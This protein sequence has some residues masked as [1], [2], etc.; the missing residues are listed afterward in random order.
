MEALRTGLRTYPGLA[1]RLVLCGEKAEVKAYNDSKATNV[2][3]T[4]TA[5][6]AL[7][8]PLVLLLGGQDKGTPYEPLRDFLTGKLRRLIFLGEAIPRLEAELGELCRFLELDRLSGSR[9][10][11]GIRFRE[12]LGRQ[13]NTRHHHRCTCGSEGGSPSL[14][15][16]IRFASAPGPRGTHSGT[17][18]RVN[19]G[20]ASH[21][22]QP[23]ATRSAAASVELHRARPNH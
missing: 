14:H 23:A 17:A 19:R 1:H 7:P 4:M 11:R 10:P 20:A 15:A 16:G 13:G 8:G 22:G 21:G 2:D 18:A 9:G 12:D 3:A 6:K 5:I